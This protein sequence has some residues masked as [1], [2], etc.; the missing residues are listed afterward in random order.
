MRV[1]AAPN[2]MKKTPK[3]AL[4]AQESNNEYDPRSQVGFKASFK[5][6][7]AAERLYRIGDSPVRSKFRRTL[8][9]IRASWRD[10]DDRDN[11]GLS[12][13]FAVTHL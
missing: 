13:T 4:H 2:Q 9:E 11:E 12:F 10:G 7:R 5:C 6:V 3:M 1:L 8:H